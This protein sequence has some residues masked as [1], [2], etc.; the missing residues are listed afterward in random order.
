MLDMNIK[1][2]HRV[3]PIDLNASSA[4]D[5]LTVT[6]PALHYEELSKGKVRATFDFFYIGK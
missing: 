5:N 6:T 2:P 3:K 1:C 4:G